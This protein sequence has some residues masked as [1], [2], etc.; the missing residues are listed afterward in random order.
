VNPDGSLTLPGGGTITTKGS[1]EIKVPGGTVI[2]S[3]GTV[4]LPI[5]KT[6]G[7]I[8]DK[9]GIIIEVGPGMS[10]FIPDSDNPLSEADIVWINP[11]NDVTGSDWFFGDVLF[12]F[13]HGLMK[14][15]SGDVFNPQGTLTRGMLVTILY[16]DVGEP[17]VSDLD[18][19]FSDIGNAYFTNPIIWASENGIVDGYGNGKFGPND[20]IKRQ[21]LAVILM[22]YAD[23]MKYELP[24]IR[25][26]SNFKDEAIIAE[27]AIKAVI[28]LYEA[29]IVNGKDGN[30][31]DPPGNATRAEVAAILHRLLES[32]S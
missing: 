14:G 19:P 11:F 16:R 15:M 6:G 4:T 32:A 10:I 8:T 29:G 18:N 24:P 30:I 2:G 5:G 26:Y 12:T 23:L 13:T 28:A 25:E 27:Y 9:N 22:R 31:F 17:D 20:S 21:D 3:E 1:S 7:A